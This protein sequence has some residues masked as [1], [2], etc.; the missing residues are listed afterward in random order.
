VPLCPAGAALGQQVEFFRFSFSLQVC[1]YLFDHHRV[2]DTSDDF[3]GTTTCVAGRNIDIEYSLEAL[4]PGHRGMLL[5]RRSLIAVYL[6]FGALA[7]FRRCY[8]RTVFAVGR[9]HAMEACQIGSRSGYQSCQ[10][11][12]KV[13]WFEDDVGSTVAVRCLQLVADVAV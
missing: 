4:C 7:S 3:D 11:C 2:F 6:A 10:A 12:D 8:Q 5:H 9:E 1:K 13:Q